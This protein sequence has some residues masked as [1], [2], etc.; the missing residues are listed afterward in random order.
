MKIRFLKSAATALGLPAMLSPAFAQTPQT[1]QSSPAVVVALPVFTHPQSVPADL[2]RIDAVLN[3]TLSF[4][5]RFTQ[6]SS[7]G[8]FAQGRIYLKR[9]GKIRFEYDSPATLLLVSDGVTL[10]QLDKQLDTMDRIPLSS[11]PLAFFLSENVRL[12]NDVE[13]VGLQ[14][15]GDGIR[16]S[17][18]DRS[19]QVDGTV[20]MVFDP[21]SLALNGWVVADG[22]GV[23]TR[24]LLSD[25]KYNDKLN[26]RLFILRDDNRRN[27]RR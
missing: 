27:R 23:E 7:D 12:E 25:L 24:I 15:T 5:G 22:F 8:S 4:S 1:P 14:K 11:T 6:N 13:V 9:P 18:R 19:G 21:A 17:A 16:V 26:P 10:T 2:A 20:T 3:N